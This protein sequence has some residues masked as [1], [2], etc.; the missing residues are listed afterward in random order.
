VVKGRRGKVVVMVGGG[1]Q[2]GEGGG[3]RLGMARR[4]ENDCCLDRRHCT[5]EF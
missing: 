3:G 2:V 5:S 1:G 4:V